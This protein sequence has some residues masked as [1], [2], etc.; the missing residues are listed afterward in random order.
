[1]S[2]SIHGGVCQFTNRPNSSPIVMRAHGEVS[3]V[4]KHDGSNPYEARHFVV[5][6]MGSAG[7]IPGRLR[8]RRR[9]GKANSKHGGTARGQPICLTD[10]PT[11][12][13]RMSASSPTVFGSWRGP[14]VGDLIASTTTAAMFLSRGRPR[15]WSRRPP[16]GIRVCAFLRPKCAQHLGLLHS[17]R[18]NTRGRPITYCST[19]PSLTALEK[20]VHVTDASLLPPLMLVE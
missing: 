8:T 15:R 3:V 5:R 1:V 4:M 6:S 19:V 11:L 20:Q 2:Q 16:R 13:Q 18:W 14:S 9:H 17:G 10:E 7:V 12:P